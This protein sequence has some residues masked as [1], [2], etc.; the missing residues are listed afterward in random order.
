M[1]RVSEEKHGK[2]R[3]VK[4]GRKER[5]E[6]REGVRWSGLAKGLE[7]RMRGREGH[8]SNEGD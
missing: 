5:K 7:G 1:H 6:R 3:E 4:E 2:K 8:G